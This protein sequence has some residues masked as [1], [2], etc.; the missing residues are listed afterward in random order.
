MK[1]PECGMMEFMPA[2]F[3]VPLFAIECV[4]GV[5][6]K[7]AD[8]FHDGGGTAHRSG[9]LNGV[10]PSD[11]GPSYMQGVLI[12]KNNLQLFDLMLF[13]VATGRCRA[14]GQGGQSDP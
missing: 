10:S 7:A 5:V 4:G 1:L 2:G 8:G 3:E 11:L 6:V 12:Q 9:K 13:Y 14:A